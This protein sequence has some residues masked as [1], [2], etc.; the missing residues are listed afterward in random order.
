MLI[1]LKSFI[2]YEFD[3]QAN[4]IEKRPREGGDF[5]INAMVMNYA[6]TNNRMIVSV[7]EISERIIQSNGN[8]ITNQR[9]YIP[10]ES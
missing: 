6:S 7:D 9:L 5:I 3:N 10:S 8:I 2:I 4:H 1:F